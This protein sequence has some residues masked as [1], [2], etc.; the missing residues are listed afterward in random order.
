MQGK[1]FIF[2]GGLHRSGTS[3]L[4]EIIRDHPEISGFKDTG[5]PKD[6]GQHLQ[7]IYQTAKSF[8]G[9]GRFGFDKRSFM[10]ETH[11][12]ATVN[13][14]EELFRQ[15]SKYWDMKS[16]YFIEKSPP[17]LVRTRFLQKMF[18]NSFFIIIFRHPIAVS[19]ATQKKWNRTCIKS[20]IKHSV[21]CYER[22]LSDLPFLAGCFILRYEE[23][24]DQPQKSMDDI[25]QFIGLQSVPIN[26]KVRTDVNDSYFY[27]WERDS[28]RWLPKFLNPIHLIYERRIRRLGYSLND[29]YK[30]QPVEFLG[31][32]KNKLN[33][34]GLAWSSGT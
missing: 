10:D 2:L 28:G 3:L 18:P 22:F 31:A 29:I 7:S 32:H 24:V 26:R 11:P 12:I 19:L 9:P 30:L 14:A 34:D 33:T 20:L 17:N 13:N 8:G 21:I 27:M 16:Q 15:W 1:T 6:E 4:H 25:F 23:F 5:V